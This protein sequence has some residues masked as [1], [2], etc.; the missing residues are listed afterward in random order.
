MGKVNNMSGERVTKVR[1]EKQQEYD[2]NTLELCG[3][4]HIISNLR[5]RVDRIIVVNDNRV[6]KTIQ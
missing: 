2:D 6:S 1:D 3:H 5:T 4:L